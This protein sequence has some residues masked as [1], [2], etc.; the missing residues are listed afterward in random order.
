M[1]L[2]IITVC[3]NAAGTI[4][5]TIQ[6]VLAQQG[7]EF[8]YMVIDGASNDGTQ[9]IVSKYSEQLTFISEPDNG[10]Y[11]AL[12]KG[13]AKSTGDV[14]GALN[15]DDFYADHNVLH[16]IASLFTK[17]KVDCCYADLDYVKDSDEKSVVRRWKAGSYKPGMFLRGWMPPHPTFFAKRNVFEKYGHYRTDY[18]ISADYEFMLR[19]MHKHKITVAYLPRTIIKMRTG[20]KSGGSMSNR[21]VSTKE[22]IKSWKVNDL[23]P[24]PFL[25]LKKKIRK[26]GQ[27]LH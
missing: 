8:E 13:I 18:V 26:L 2:S 9:D 23:K 15:A 16:D 12:N 1:K 10:M 21:I 11:E 24:P 20:G 7:V 27:F 4:E 22:D 14:I 6:S 17:L 19:V 25:T 3:R 5:Q